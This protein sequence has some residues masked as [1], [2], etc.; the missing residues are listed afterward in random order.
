[1]I[2]SPIVAAPAITARSQTGWKNTAPCAASPVSRVSMIRHQS[3]KLCS[4][5]VAPMRLRFSTF[6]R[7]ALSGTWMIAGIRNRFAAAT[8]AWPKLPALA[9]TIA[10]GGA[11][12]ST[13][14]LRALVAPRIL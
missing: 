4:W 10:R 14:A 11:P 3:S 5:T 1:M 2:S 12:L 6:T 8:I 7:A 9:L 13:A